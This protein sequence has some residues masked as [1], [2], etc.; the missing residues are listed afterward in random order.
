MFLPPDADSWERRHRCML[1]LV[2]LANGAFVTADGDAKPETR[3]LGSN[4]NKEK[5]V[6]DAISI[7][8]RRRIPTLWVCLWFSQIKV[9]AAMTGRLMNLED[10]GFIVAQY[11]E[12]S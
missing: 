10:N 1:F 9:S 7:D 4:D 3:H 6:T 8:R 12:A 2:G 5:I 11:M